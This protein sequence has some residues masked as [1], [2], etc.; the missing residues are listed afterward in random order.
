MSRYV[1]TLG[2]AFAR[3]I[4][5]VAQAQPAQFAGY[6]ANMEFWLA[7]LEHLGMI[8]NGYEQR[9]AGMRASYARYL[10]QYGGPHNRDEFGYPYQGV[11]ATTSRA[12]RKRLLARARQ[13]ISSVVER[14]LAMG[15]IEFPE[16]DT[17]Q[18]RIETLGRWHLQ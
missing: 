10:E 14:A 13:A 8:A 7:E 17:L 9:I 4:E 11:E 12:D 2:E 5:R 6:W 18:T 3:T 15:L 1:A 16:H